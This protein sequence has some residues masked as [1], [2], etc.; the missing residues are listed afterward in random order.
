[1]EPYP[2]LRLVCICPRNAARTA[3]IVS[4]R[5]TS[6]A[7]I[8][9]TKECGKPTAE[10]AASI[11]GDSTFARPTTATS[12]RTNTP[13]LSSARNPPGRGV[14]GSGAVSPEPSAADPETEPATGR[15]K[16]RCR[17]VWVNTNNPYSSNEAHAAK[18]NCDAAYSGPGSLTVKFGNTIVNAANVVTQARA[19]P[20][21][22]GWNRVI[23]YRSE[24]TNNDTP[25][26]PFVVIIAA[27]NTV[28]RANEDDSSLAE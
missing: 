27:A 5:S 15:K 24:P 21:P 25:T 28:S 7:M 19:A 22:S 17:S 13:A 3:A 8:T 23:P 12:A 2:R 20:A 6:T 10:T 4:G 26:I 14:C 9:P 1:A 18:T 11:A 16:S